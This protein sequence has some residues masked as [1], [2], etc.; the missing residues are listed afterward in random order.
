VPGAGHIGLVVSTFLASAVE[1]V[2]ALT[3]VL[4]MGLTRGW[5]SALWGTAA[6]VA[7]LAAV[8]AVFG[9]AL[10]RW[11]PESALQLGIGTLLLIFG[12]QWLRKAI[13]RSAGLKALHDE[14]ATFAEEEAA[15]R[16][17]TAE[18]HLGID[19]FGFAVAF[20]GVFLEGL[21]VVF[22]VITFGLNAGSVP[23]AAAGAVAAALLVVGAGVIV[24]RPLAQVP[25]NTIKFVVG[26]LLTTFGTFWAT[27]GLG[28]FAADS[29][30]LEWPGGE[31]SLLVVLAAWTVFALVAVRLLRRTAA[32]RTT[33]AEVAP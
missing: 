3:I 7:A 30:P 20:K 10:T 13:L 23:L 25:E 26:L 28:A 22:I 29:Q 6:A 1:F 9:Y 19:G 11:L 27:E 17:A 33:P 24:H 14:E 31:L 5:R 8:T 32:P 21:E 4:A 2:E 12:L 15:A 16:A 18:Q